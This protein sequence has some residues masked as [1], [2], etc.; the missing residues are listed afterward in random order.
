M[1][2]NH[3]YFRNVNIQYQQLAIIVKLPDLKYTFISFST[4]TVSKTILSSRTEP[5]ESKEESQSNLH[6]TSQTNIKVKSEKEDFDI[7]YIDSISINGKYISTQRALDVQCTYIV[8]TLYELYVHCTS[9][10][11]WVTMYTR[12]Q[13]FR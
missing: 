11:R 3:L 1:Q 9:S 8:R 7:G 4:E 13:D 12:L 2:C 5:D 10:A 6:L